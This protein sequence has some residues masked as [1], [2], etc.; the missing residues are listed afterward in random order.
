MKERGIIFCQELIPGVMNGTITLTSRVIKPQPDGSSTWLPALSAEPWLFFPDGLAGNPRVLRCPFRP[1]EKRYVKET[2]YYNGEGKDRAQNVAYRV[3]GEMPK[4][5]RDA[6]THWRSP[7]MMPRW[8]ARTWIEILSVKPARCQEITLA[9]IKASGII[10]HT[11]EPGFACW[12]D[13]V[14]YDETPKMA[15]AA[16]WDRLNAKRGFPLSAN[17][18]VWR[19]T[20]KLAVAS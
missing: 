8:A 3:D 7:M 9:E 20:F 16:L 17:L 15:Y 1:G 6:G 4:Y 12:W 14:N 2:W 18:W 10:S 19:M 13:G 11:R 5:I